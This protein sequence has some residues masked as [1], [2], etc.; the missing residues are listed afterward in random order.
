MENLA[1]RLGVIGLSEG[2]GHPYSWS[3]LINGY[4]PAAMATC[5]F[6]VI[7]AY[8]E[9]ARANEHPF[10]GARVTH[11]WAQDQ[12]PAKDIAK[13]C[14]IPHICGSYEDMIGQVDGV[15]LARDDAENHLSMSAPFLK[16]G[17]PV[18]IDKPLAYDIPTA[19]QIFEVARDPRHV[20]SCTGLRYAAEFCWTDELA[21]KIGELRSIDA[22]APKNWK[23]YAIHPLEPALCLLRFPQGE[24]EVAFTHTDGGGGILTAHWK[25][26]K[27]LTLQ[28]TGIPVSPISLHL[29][30]TKGSAF[31]LFKDTASAFR[32]LLS[33]FVD[34]VRDPSSKE[35]IPQEHTFACIRLIEKG[36]A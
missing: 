21:N 36:L 32:R 5:P 15:L 19:R 33:A 2:N 18:L 6:P 24:P 8:L 9:A 16:A 17:I 26:G 20:F 4:D 25:C 14:K 30:G 12:E 28:A 23:Q 10:R 3:A 34:T 11:V 31:L 13:A 7:P 27:S 29:H 1:I 35:A 22:T